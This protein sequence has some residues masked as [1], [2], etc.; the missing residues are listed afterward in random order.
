MF[1]YLE[2]WYNFILLKNKNPDRLQ[3]SSTDPDQIGLSIRKTRIWC[4]RTHPFMRLLFAWGD[5]EDPGEAGWGGGGD[6]GVP[7]PHH[8]PLARLLDVGVQNWPQHNTTIINIFIVSRDF[9]LTRAAEPSHFAAAPAPAPALSYIIVHQFLKI[10]A[11]GSLFFFNK[12]LHV[13]VSCGLF[14]PEVGIC[15]HTFYIFSTSF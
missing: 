2:F 3:R 7:H 6:G 14:R 4:K 11:H 1:F 15:F 9:D 13:W 10:N 5:G 8:A 12:L